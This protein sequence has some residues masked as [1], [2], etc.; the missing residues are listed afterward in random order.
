[1]EDKT[2]FAIAEMMKAAYRWYG[3][4]VDVIDVTILHTAVDYKRLT[5]EGL[6]WE[7]VDQ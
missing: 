7:L 2:I 6:K 4:E 1:M 5:E 3:V